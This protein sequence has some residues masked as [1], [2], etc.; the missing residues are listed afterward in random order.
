MST[1]CDV[2]GYAHHTV[3]CMFN[4]SYCFYQT[5][6]YRSRICISDMQIGDVGCM[7]DITLWN[8]RSWRTW[9]CCFYSTH[10]HGVV[11]PSTLM[12]ADVWKGFGVYYGLKQHSTW[13]DVLPVQV[14]DAHRGCTVL[15]VV[16]VFSSACQW[17]RC[18]AR[19]G[20]RRRPPPVVRTERWEWDTKRNLHVCV[21]K[22]AHK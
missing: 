8:Q 3:I 13:G 12:K 1:E 6:I 17:P 20:G 2:L 4:M 11:C 14:R 22:Y 21:Q 9:E 7:S 18:L 15:E 5:C 10:R 19:P 16:P